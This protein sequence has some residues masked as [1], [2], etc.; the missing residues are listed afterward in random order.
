MISMYRD[1]E[2]GKKI[3]S[4]V[5]KQI[6][7]GFLLL[8]F[9]ML[10]E[11]LTGYG[12][13]G[14]EFFL[15]LNDPGSTDWQVML[16]RWN[17]FETVH[18][19]AWCLIFNGIVQGLLSLKGNW[20]NRRNLIIS[21]I[22]M[23]VAVV[24]LTQPVWWLV[25]KAL[26][27]FPFDNFS[28]GYYQL[29]YPHIGTESF[30][31]IFRTP[32]LNM[33]AAPMEPLFPYLAVSFIGSI[34]GIV[35][36]KPKDEINKK[37]PRNLFLIG[38]TMFIVGLLGVFAVLITVVIQGGAIGIDNAIELYTNF[39]DHRFWSGDNQTLGFTIPQFAWLAQFMAVNG[40]SILSIASLLRLIE[41]RGISKKFANRTKIIRRFGIVAFSNYNNQWIYFV[42]WEITSLMFYQTHY[43][44][45][46]W[47]GML[48]VLILTFSV[49]SLI[50]WGWEKVGY[51]L[52]LE[53]SIR[54]IANN[55]IPIR[56]QR[57]PESTK[58]WQRGLIDVKRQ[59]YDVDWVDIY[60]D[61][62]IA[63]KFEDT[64]MAIETDDTVESIGLSQTELRDS[65]FALTLS[66]IG[67]FSIFFVISSFIALKVSLS[68]RKYEG[69]NSIN[70]AALIISII[71]IVLLLL[72]L[73]VLSILR[74]GILGLF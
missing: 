5:F 28:H 69:K 65:K 36:S 17:H 29:M 70:K 10:C 61:S 20:K 54:T 24:A 31:Q 12:G 7:G 26:P 53:W 73:V 52:S 11:G 37:F 46:L 63:A 59:F 43:Q 22:V 51:I 34:I 71:T 33:L 47:L 3:R 50:L 21:Y 60:D 23:A 66:L 19:I 68:A 18:T 30:W 8:T 39:V 67:M 49:Y 44:K 48:V 40:F 58:W 57:F 62:Q 56:R 42:M 6:F 13:L 4:L 14:G 16:W 1:L 45:P 74:I 9:A 55:I 72:V 25:G 27:G 32:F 38:L 41:F 64:K 15:N 35:L 2:H